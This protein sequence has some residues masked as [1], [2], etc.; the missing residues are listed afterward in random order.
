MTEKVEKYYDIRTE[1]EWTRLNR[2]RMEMAI[3]LRAL[4]DYLPSP[5]ATILDIGG[6]PGRYAIAL[7]GHGYQVTLLDLSQENLTVAQEKAAMAEVTLA[8]TVHA[9][10][11]HLPM[12]PDATCDA[13]LLLGPLYHLLQETDRHAAVAEA[14]RV[15]KPG[16][17]L[18]SA[19]LGPYAVISYAATR[20]P[21]WIVQQKE[22][23]ERILST[24]QV[25][26][27]RREQQLFRRCLL[28]SP[29][30][31]PAVDG[32]PSSDNKGAR[33]LRRRDWLDR[34]RSECAERRPVGRMG[35]PQ[36]PP[37]QRPIHSG[38]RRSSAVRRAKGG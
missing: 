23:L 9:N 29:D 32:S 12:I 27:R 7:A 31:H 26:T 33:L 17:M 5:P 22:A 8:G 36:L 38:P 10:A 30:P 11:T 15:L 20:D 24:G 21:A 4:A 6:G 14:V 16:G 25:Q 2:H 34:S 18:F 13:V 35:R 19:F 37:Q 1:I 28:F 3:T